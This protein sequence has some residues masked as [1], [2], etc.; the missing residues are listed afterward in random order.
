LPPRLDVVIGASSFNLG[1]AC[2]RNWASGGQGVRLADRRDDRLDQ[3]RIGSI[4]DEQPQ[5]P[6]SEALRSKWKIFSRK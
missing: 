5:L 2:L 4:G 3:Q 6:A 1:M